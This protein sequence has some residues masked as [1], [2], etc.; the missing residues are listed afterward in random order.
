MRDKCRTEL[1]KFSGNLKSSIVCCVSRGTLIHDKK[2]DRLI[3]RNCLHNI[4]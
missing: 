3:N 2:S 4:F 1:N